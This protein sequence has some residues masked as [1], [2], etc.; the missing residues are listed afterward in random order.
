MNVP[1]LDLKAQY[2]SIKSEVDNVIKQTV[3][4][5]FFIMGKTVKDFENEVARY[6]ETNYAYGCAS[7]SDALLLA[8]TAIDL[9]SDEYVITTPFTFF[10]TAGAISRAGATPIFVDID[11]H[12]FNINP[13]KIEAALQGDHPVIKR[14]NIDPKKIRAVIPVH[15]Y[16]QMAE[17]NQIMNLAS[18]YGLTVIEDAAQSI[19]SELR[20]KKAGNFGDFGCFSFFPSKNLGA[21]GDAGLITVKDKDFAEKV[22]ILRLHGARPKYHNKYIGMNSRLDALQAAVLSVKLTHLDNWSSTRREKALNYN[23]L[24]VEAGIVQE[25]KDCLDDCTCLGKQ[26]CDLADD[27]LMLPVE[28][29]GDPAKGGK[30][31]YHQYTIR[32]KHRDEVLKKLKERGI[33]SAVYYPVPM[34]MQEC[35]SMLGYKEEDLPHTVCAANQAL[36]LPMYPE[37]TP[38]QQVY[39]VEQLKLILNESN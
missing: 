21:Y 35:Y 1:L 14:E 5:Q 32:V 23:R 17:M 18:E 11:P 12:T 28:K 25:P 30:H 27:L 33:G 20:G 3:E 19:G 4:S 24:F 16:G 9:K 15:L 31:I 39:V 6:C 38:E 8:L 13:I 34:H 10:A 22:D 2:I 26:Q 29:E 7:G 37:L 36:S